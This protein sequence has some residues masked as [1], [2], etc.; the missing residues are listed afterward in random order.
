MY[1]VTFMTMSYSFENLLNAMA[2]RDEKIARM[3][4]ENRRS[5]SPGISFTVKLS[6]NNIFE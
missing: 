4:V 6:G 2:E 3:K 1:N 5:S